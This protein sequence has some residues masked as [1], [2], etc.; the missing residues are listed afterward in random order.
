VYS[1]GSLPLSSGLPGHIQVS[2]I[3]SPPPP[4]PVLHAQTISFL[5]ILSFL[6]GEMFLISGNFQKMK[7]YNRAAY[8]ITSK[9]VVEPEGPQMATWRRVACW[10]SKATLAQA[11]ASACAPTPTR[12]NAYA[13]TRT[14]TQ[15][16]NSLC[17]STATIIRDRAS[18]LRY[19]YIACL[20]Y[21]KR[22]IVLIVIKYLAF[23]NKIRSFMLCTLSQISY[24]SLNL[25]D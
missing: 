6:W 10:I 9:Y 15:L 1:F 8:D 17:F 13:R 21:L 22:R 4:P 7:I 24:A 11:D 16:C 5:L 20:V 23:V 14:H 2:L 19:T 12:T 25:E 3:P 18:L